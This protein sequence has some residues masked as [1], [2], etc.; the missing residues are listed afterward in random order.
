MNKFLIII[1]IVFSACAGLEER[2]VTAHYEVLIPQKC[3]FRK[4][5]KPTGDNETL[6]QLVDLIKYTRELEYFRDAC[7][8]DIKND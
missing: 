3:Q 5:V 2:T 8:G 6:L 1:I 7:S 4:P